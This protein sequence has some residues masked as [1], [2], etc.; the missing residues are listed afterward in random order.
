MISTQLYR[1]TI[2]D[3]I[4][5]YFFSP[6]LNTET[7]DTK[8][9]GSQ[10]VAK[11]EDDELHIAVSVVGHDPKKVTVDLTEDKIFVKAVKD[12]ETK[13]L[14]SAFVRDIDDSFKLGRD[15][16]GLTAKAKIDNGILKITVQKKEESKPKKLSITF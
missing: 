11:V 10:T 4:E 2:F 1:P 16:N 15:Y 12:T 3:E 5:K 6:N 13:S 14:E 8:V 9:I 7:S